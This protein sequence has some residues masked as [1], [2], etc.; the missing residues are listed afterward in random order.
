VKGKYEIG[1]DEVPSG[2][3]YIAHIDQTC[4]G[5]V[6]FEDSKV[7]GRYIGKIADG[8][9]PQPREELSDADP[10]KWK[11]EDADG[12]PRDPWVK[13]WF[14]PLIGVEG[15]DFVT[16]VTGSHGGANAICN[17]L[18]VY[19]HRMADGFLPIIALKTSSYK[20][21]KYG[22]IEEP[23][24]PIVGWHG[25]P[26]NGKSGGNPNTGNAAA[27]VDLDDSIPF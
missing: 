24:F 3:E 6:K 21:K 23:D 12:K 13:Q 4:R 5:W 22:R 1:D 16:F 26:T 11:E 2:T 7:V 19:G 25:R 14:V 15:N 9:R 20:H 18:R 17:L 8:F 10:K 27:N